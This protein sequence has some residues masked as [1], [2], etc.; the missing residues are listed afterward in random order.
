MNILSSFTVYTAALH[1][2]ILILFSLHTSGLGYPGLTW[3]YCISTNKSFSSPKTSSRTPYS[4]SKQQEKQKHSPETTINFSSTLGRRPPTSHTPAD[5][6]GNATRCPPQRRQAPTGARGAPRLPRAPGPNL[7]QA[8]AGA[9]RRRPCAGASRGHTPPRTNERAP[10]ALPFCG[11]TCTCGTPHPLRT[12]RTC[13]HPNP[14]PPPPFAE[15]APPCHADGGMGRDTPGPAAE[16][17]R[18]PSG[19]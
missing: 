10:L 12:C 5:S 13:L 4:N 1:A 3:I 2:L 6:A 14:H 8:C 7:P 15:P 9:Q 18:R 16:R 11:S 17:R 19:A